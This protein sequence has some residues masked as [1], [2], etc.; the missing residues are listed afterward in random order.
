MKLDIG[1]LNNKLEEHN[2]LS[3]VSFYSAN[4][5]K[6]ILN[7]ILYVNNDA[8]RIIRRI[9]GDQHWIDNFDRIYLTFEIH[10]EKLVKSLISAKGGKSCQLQHG[11]K[12]KN[13]LNTGI[14][15]NKNTK[16]SY[17]YSPWCKDETK[18]TDKRLQKLSDNRIGTGNPMY[19]TTLSDESK[20]KKSKIM[21][22]KILDGSFTPN[23]NNRNTHW[24]SSFD[25]K[26]FRSSWEAIYYSLHTEAIYESLRIPYNYNNKNYVYI[27]DFINHNTR[28]AIEI[29]P[30]ALLNKDREKS[31]IVALKQWCYD[32]N[33]TMVIITEVDI[34]YM[35]SLVI[36]DKFDANTQRKIR[37]LNE[38]YKKNR[39]R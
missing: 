20:D 27:V 11:D 19:G 17:P 30:F 14:P 37:K 2:Q 22:Q 13:N 24:D 34:E 3:R 33:Y 21:K 38:T 7:D 35:S 8:L 23:S 15:W 26:K 6:V 16:G 25:N 31:K 28:A 1:K 5:K 32:N 36:I 4:P 12:L 10:A 39:D 29:K 9:N 18:Y